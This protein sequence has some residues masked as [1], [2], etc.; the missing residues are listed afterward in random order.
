M[1]D[2]PVSVFGGLLQA[3]IRDDY[4]TER[5]VLAEGVLFMVAGIAASIATTYVLATHGIFV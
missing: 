1:P 4:V 3:C 5:G 2:D